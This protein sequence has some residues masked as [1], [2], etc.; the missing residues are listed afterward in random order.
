MSSFCGGKAEMRLGIL[1]AT[2]LHPLELC[3]TQLPSIQSSPV[4]FLLRLPPLE[5][6][7][8]TFTR[9]N[10]ANSVV[11]F[12]S[13]AGLSRNNIFTIQQEEIQDVS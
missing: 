5:G 10:K 8:L 9:F 6:T 13:I 4:L 3:Q 2:N 12:L 11:F 7:N 1:C